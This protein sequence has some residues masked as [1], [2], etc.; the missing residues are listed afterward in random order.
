[1][2]TTTPPPDR[3]ERDAAAG[4]YEC[5]TQH[6]DRKWDENDYKY[7]DFQAGWDAALRSKLV[8][9]MAEA[10][11]C[12]SINPKRTDI[13]EQSEQAL[14]AYRAALGGNVGDK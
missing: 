5:N 9:E 3:S 12:N 2:S 13:M 4:I 6:P 14:E 1:M 8:T 7:R 10:L 11:R